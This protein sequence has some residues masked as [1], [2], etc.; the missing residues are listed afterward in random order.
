MTALILIWQVSCLKEC[1][2]IPRCQ[3]WATLRHLRRLFLVVL[4]K[5]KF[6]WRVSTWP[7]EMNGQISHYLCYEL[8]VLFSRDGKRWLQPLISVFFT[9][10]CYFVSFFHLCFLGPVILNIVYN[11]S[12]L[13]SCKK[14]YFEGFRY[15]RLFY[16]LHQT[17][18]HSLHQILGMSILVL[19]LV[20]G[21]WNRS[22]I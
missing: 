6:H 9:C 11:L 19:L 20:A 17:V 5:V 12:L 21:G 15:I 10:Q 13:G 18:V 2:F 1:W 16:Y 4:C 22:R 14:C 3:W 7:I 8:L